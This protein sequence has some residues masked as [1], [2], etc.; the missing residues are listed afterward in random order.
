MAPAGQCFHVFHLNRSYFLTFPA[1]ALIVRS[2]DFRDSGP[3]CSR[4]CRG[5]RAVEQVRRLCLGCGHGLLFQATMPARNSRQTL[6][7]A[8]V[9][10]LSDAVAVAICASTMGT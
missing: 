5:L 3:P 7:H 4:R 8:V 2:H 1:I 9:V 6:S 10:A